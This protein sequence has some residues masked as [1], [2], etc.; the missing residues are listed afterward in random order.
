MVGVLL[1]KVF[2]LWEKLTEWKLALNCLIFTIGS[3]TLFPLGKTNRMETLNDPFVENAVM[4]FP[5]GKT[6][7]IKSFKRR[8]KPCVFL[9][10]NKHC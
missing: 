4:L 9:I 8:I 3:L 10:R 6:N 1:A 7:R 5:L 2:S